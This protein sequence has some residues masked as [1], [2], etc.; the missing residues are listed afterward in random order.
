MAQMHGPQRY[1]LTLLTA[2]SLAVAGLC[3]L[4]LAA[5]VAT[6]AAS[7]AAIESC[8]KLADD[9]DRLACFDKEVAAEIARESHGGSGAASVTPS[10]SAAASG[11]AKPPKLTEEQK[12]GFGAEKVQKLEAPA[13]APVPLKTLTTKIQ[14]VTTNANGREVF[15]LENGQV[16]RQVELDPKFTVHPGDAVQIEHGAFGS[17][18]LSANVHSHTHVTR[19]R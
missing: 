13:D 11:A 17:F 14:S 10:T 4:G 15:T 2:K 9:K 12:M 7:T 19:M 6:A 3:A 1:K 16:W 5:E 8:T 18:W